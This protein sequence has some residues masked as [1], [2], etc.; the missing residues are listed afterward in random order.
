VARIKEFE[1]MLKALKFDG[2]IRAFNATLDELYINLPRDTATHKACGLITLCWHANGNMSRILCLG[3]RRTPT[4][5]KHYHV[6]HMINYKANRA[7]AYGA[8]A[9]E[10]RRNT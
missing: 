7:V 5:I 9:V 10:R 1:D 2:T 4:Q 6:I 3:I 8:I